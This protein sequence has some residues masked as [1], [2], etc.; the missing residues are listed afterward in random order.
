[1]KK[2]DNE[3]IEFPKLEQWKD[4]R[5]LLMKEKDTLQKKAQ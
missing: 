5:P 4:D 3:K 1:V 2:V